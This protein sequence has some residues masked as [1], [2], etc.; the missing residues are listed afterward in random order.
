MH[1]TLSTIGLS[2]LLRL[3]IQW[4]QNLRF[5]SVG[6][7][8]SKL[9]DPLWREHAIKGSRSPLLGTE[10]A[11]VPVP[12]WWKQSEQKFQF[13]FGGNR[14]SKGSRSPLVETERA[15]VPD[16][17]WWEHGEQRFQIPSGGNRTSKGSRSPLEL[18]K[19]P[20]FKPGEVRIL[21]YILCL[22]PKTL[23]F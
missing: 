5:P 19:F 7:E 13:P 12:L 22:L 16:P 15:K 14:A 2:W 10:R 21:L 6:T 4:T 3:G 9:P 8:L 18:S 23:P 17:L 1:I 11:K 20:A